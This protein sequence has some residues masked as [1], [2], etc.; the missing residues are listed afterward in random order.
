MEELIKRIIDIEHNAQEYL[1]EAAKETEEI[2][3]SVAVKT[4]QLE[5]DYDKKV[6]QHCEQVKE[7]KDSEADEKIR[8]VTDNTDNIINSL[9]NRLNENLEAWTEKVF[10]NIVGL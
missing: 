1:A 7:H 6:Q 3:K 9:E 8:E 10:N 2:E 4:K 5:N